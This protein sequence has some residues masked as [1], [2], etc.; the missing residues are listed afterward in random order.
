MHHL[1]YQDEC[2]RHSI[3]TKLLLGVELRWIIK[4]AVMAIQRTVKLC[5][6]QNEIALKKSQLKW[7]N[8]IRCP[9]H[10]NYLH[11]CKVMQN[12]QMKNN[13]NP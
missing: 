13:F 1:A 10:I 6:T 4:N 8:N 9:I 3:D 2:K 7:N 12:L 11:C 5:S